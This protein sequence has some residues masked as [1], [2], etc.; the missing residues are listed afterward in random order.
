MGRGDLSKLAIPER[1][2]KASAREILEAHRRSGMTVVRFAAEHGF[3]P[4]RL[5]RWR[6]H[7]RERGVPS[8]EIPTFVPVH[9]TNTQHVESTSAQMDLI[10]G[11][12]RTLRVGSNFDEQA[13]C[14]L[15]G[16]LESMPPC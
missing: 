3:D 2:T 7:L 16:A 12:G 14:R 11:N 13:L 10:L 9:I 6:R 1:W 15:V 4:M 5:Y 8:I